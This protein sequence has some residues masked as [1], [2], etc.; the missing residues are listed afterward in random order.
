MK[1]KEKFNYKELG[2]GLLLIL[3]YFL[4]ANIISSFFSFFIKSNILPSKYKNIYYLLI[5]LI[6]AIVYG[7]L[8]KKEL[9]H[10]FNNF[11][12][13]YKKD[14]SK[15]FKYY[16]R[17]VFIMYASNY[18]LIFL[19]NLSKS[20]NE[21]QN[22]EMIKQSMFTHSIIII[23]LAP[24]L[25]ELVFRLGFKKMT[26]NIKLFSII[27]GVLF[28][29]VHVISSLSNPVMI[30]LTIPYSAVGISLGYAFRETDN[31]FASISMHMIH[32]T[33]TITF[34]IIAIIGGII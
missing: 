13:N 6:L 30:L 1:K 25:E 12:K 26:N 17:G 9:I 19:F 4:G 29:F 7:L 14:I 33:I 32:N 10:D 3:A 11:K 27:T 15:A 18:L 8:Y 20:V 24:F 28:G 2:K 23:L 16:L 21:M 22:I 34:I 5:Y 31:I